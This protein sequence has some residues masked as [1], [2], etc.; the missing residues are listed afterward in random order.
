MVFPRHH[1]PE[2]VSFFLRQMPDKLRQKQAPANR[3]IAK[4][5]RQ[6]VAEMNSL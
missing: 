3:L 6:G 4:V 2:P 1:R 5:F